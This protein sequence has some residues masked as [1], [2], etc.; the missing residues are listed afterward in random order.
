[1]WALMKTMSILKVGQSFINQWRQWKTGST[2]SLNEAA[3]KLTQDIKGIFQFEDLEI[4][5]D[6]DNQTLQVF[7]D[8]K[9]YRLNELGAGMAQ[10]F[11]V[12]A[13]ASTKNPSFVLID[14]PELNLHP[15]L[16]LDFLTT[17]ASYSRLGVIFA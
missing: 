12:L 15:T 8:G 7:I 5:P 13:N 3:Y 10:F 2:R 11:L 17:L 1:M 16:Q 14:E 6:H 9:S 4:N